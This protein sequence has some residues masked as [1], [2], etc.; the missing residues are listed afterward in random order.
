M[1]S[2][3]WFVSN[4]SATVFGKLMVKY[5]F[6]SFEKYKHNLFLHF[7]ACSLCSISRSSS[8]YLQTVVTGSSWEMHCAAPVTKVRQ[9]PRSSSPDPWHKPQKFREIILKFIRHTQLTVTCVVIYHLHGPALWCSTPNKYDPHQ[10]KPNV[11]TQHYYWCLFWNVQVC[12][13]A[14]SKS[15]TVGVED[16]QRQ[17]LR[18]RTTWCE[19]FTRHVGQ[20]LTGLKVV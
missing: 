15:A 7:L 3:I 1:F 13:C 14:Q 11:K 9:G 8:L 12:G 19:I 5:W 16:T 6:I 4:H 18:I 2:E 17:G 10:L 20:S